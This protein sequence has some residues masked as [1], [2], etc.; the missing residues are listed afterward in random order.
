MGALL[1]GKA[2]FEDF[3]SAARLLT[4]KSD[5]SPHPVLV[6]EVGEMSLMTG[7]AGVGKSWS[8]L[9]LA[10]QMWRQH[11]L[12]T[13]FLATEGATSLARRVVTAWPKGL[14][15]GLPDLQTGFGRSYFGALD[16][17]GNQLADNIGMV[18]LDVASALASDENASGDWN[19]IRDRLQTLTDGRLF[20]AVHHTG[21]DPSKGPR[22]T[23]RFTDDAAYDFQVSVDV[24][25]VIHL[26]PGS[27]SRGAE[28]EPWE[29]GLEIQQGWPVEVDPDISKRF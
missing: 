7:P 11:K 5:H 14:A 9:W 19:Y 23:S 4:L 15:K 1:Q 18:V 29:V 10:E 3:L 24:K 13:L 27:K 17:I 12:R 2:A 25:K 6:G 22:G 28:G 8:V 16:K 26:T 20:V 21:K